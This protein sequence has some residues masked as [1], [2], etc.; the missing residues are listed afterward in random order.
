MAYN[1]NND[2]IDPEPASYQE[3]NFLEY[4]NKWEDDVSKEKKR[5]KIIFAPKSDENILFE[6]KIN[7]YIEENT[8]K[9]DI[10][11]IKYLKTSILIIYQ[12]K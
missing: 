4:A 12:P 9:I 1:Y 10:I 7:S 6:D 3:S 2:I 5:V 8:E 11:D